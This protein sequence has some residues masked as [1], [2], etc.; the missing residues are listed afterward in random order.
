VPFSFPVQVGL[1]FAGLNVD[2]A[3]MC[4]R[5]SVSTHGM[6][7][8][9][10]GSISAGAARCDSTPGDV[11]SVVW[12]SGDLT[13]SPIASVT[14]TFAGTMWATALAWN[15]TSTSI[16]VNWPNFLTQTLTAPVGS[17]FQ[18]DKQ[19]TAIDMA[20]TRLN[21][22]DN[23][24][25]YSTWGYSVRACGVT[26]GDV[27]NATAALDSGLVVRF[28]LLQEAN[29]W[30]VVV[31]RAVVNVD[32]LPRCAAIARDRCR[33]DQLC[34]W[35]SLRVTSCRKTRASSKCAAQQAQQ[36]GLLGT[37]R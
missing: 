4:S 6:Y 18:G 5:I 8:H 21:Y 34:A 17:R 35:I 13:M 22:I 33:H 30:N 20:M 29:A 25:D 12:D 16:D 36:Q 27:S 32:R 2:C 1:A 7:R 3:T 14:M 28:S 31:S 19:P 26:V 9:Q 37:G 23:I 24:T 10:I 11:C 15:V